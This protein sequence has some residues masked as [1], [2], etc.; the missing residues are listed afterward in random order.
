VPL[1]AFVLAPALARPAFVRALAVLCVPQLVISA[2]GWQ[3]P[4]FLWPRG[5][6]V[7]RV[8]DAVP[9]IGPLIN[10]ALP[11]F[12]TGPL[13]PIAIAAT[14]AICVAVIVVIHRAIAGPDAPAASALQPRP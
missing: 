9:G 13:D 5:D 7:N 4:R 1:F 2:I 8:L 10:D 14:I 3:R 6:G 12:R 11:S